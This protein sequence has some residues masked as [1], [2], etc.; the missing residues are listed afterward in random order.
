MVNGLDALLNEL[1]RREEYG[2][3]HAGSAH[4]DPK[5]TVHVTLEEL[6]LRCW[7]DLLPFGVQQ[8]VPLVDALRGVDGI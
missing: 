4:R 5:A 1:K 8:R 7:F 2:V 3:D 6:N